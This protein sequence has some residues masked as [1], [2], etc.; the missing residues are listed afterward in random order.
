MLRELVERI[1]LSE[2]GWRAPFAVYG[3]ALVVLPAIV[4]YLTEPRRMGRP[5]TAAQ[6]AAFPW[7][8]VV[9]LFLAA[10]FN[11]LIFYLS[12][13]QLPF[14][15]HALGVTSSSV[16]GITLGVFNLA[17]AAA[18][19]GYGYLRGGIGILGGFSLG[20]GLMA[21]GYGIIAAAM[22]QAFVV[23]G[24]VVT[25]MGMGCIMPG[26]M[27][28]AMTIAPPPVRGRIAGWLTA[29]IFL[30]QFLSPLASQPWVGWFGYAAAFRDM[31]LLLALASLLTVLLSG[32]TRLRRT[33][34]RFS[35]R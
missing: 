2:V 6:T 33:V 7:L 19:L 32:K 27:A 23:A 34:Y 5:L 25:G 29:S 15:L 26:L 16:V 4:V 10:A 24:L 11:S 31:S 8:A 9:G 1:V 28:G 17:F 22:S 14:H 30:G 12:P 13:A 3:L 20:F 18:S 21:A 35:R